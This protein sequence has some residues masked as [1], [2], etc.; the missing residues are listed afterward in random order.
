MLYLPD[1]NVLITAHNQYYPLSRVP[2][3]WDWLLHMGQIGRLRIPDEIIEEIAGGT[4]E[5]ASWLSDAE[6]LSA[7]RLDE[8]V[9]A[10]FVQRVI[11][12]GYAPDLD[13][14]EI[15]R[16]G[17]DPFLIAYA[18]RDVATRCVVTTE[19]SKPSKQRA[20]RHV[21]DVCRSLGIRWMDSFELV[22]TLDFST[23]WRSRL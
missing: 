17:C 2:E 22:R 14:N 12:Q 11:E 16:L 19:V 7:L 6:H 21:P 4:D 3:F 23:G 18:L 13:D 9:E 20:N 15:L 1:A 5:L 8:E 10:V